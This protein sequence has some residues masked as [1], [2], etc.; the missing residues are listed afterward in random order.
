MESSVLRVQLDG[1]LL[2]LTLTRAAKRNALNLELCRALVGAVE[3]ARPDEVGCVL[4]DAEGPAFCAGMDL[5]E[6]TD[7]DADELAAVHERLFTMNRWA[8]VPIVA[9]VQGRA[10]AGGVG[11]VAQAHIVVAEE[12]AQFGLTEVR[13]GM[14]PMLIYR[15]VEAAIGERRALEWSLTGR[16]VGA[17]EAQAAGLVHEIREF[18]RAEELAL[19]IAGRGAEAIGFG[20]RYFRES[21]GLGFTEA[22]QLAARLR[23]ELMATPAYMESAA[24]FKPKV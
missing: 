4:L 14:W 18:P 5:G 19:E 22:G 12:M 2:R 21:R 11:L 15:S 7:V 20:M 9:A 16:L 10:L 17:A 24:K 23:K 8:H 13:I 3:I 6:S 1:R